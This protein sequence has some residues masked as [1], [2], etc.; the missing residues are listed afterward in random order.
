LLDSF[1]S[2]TVVQVVAHGGVYFRD[3]G[4]CIVVL[5]SDYFNAG[6]LRQVKPFCRRVCEPAYGVDH[7]TAKATVSVGDVVYYQKAYERDTLEWSAD[8]DPFIFAARMEVEAESKQVVHYSKEDFDR[9]FRSTPGGN[10]DNWKLEE[11]ALRIPGLWTTN[12]W[13]E[14]V[15]D[16]Y[17]ASTTTGDGTKKEG[18]FGNLIAATTKPDPFEKRD[19]GKYA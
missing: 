6:S 16:R 3:E 12:G 1:F 7:L 14:M 9:H 18:A 15:K 19:G 2:Q 8:G 13:K 4:D 17:S 10:E 5:F 11:E